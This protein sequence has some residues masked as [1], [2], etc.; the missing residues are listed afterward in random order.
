MVLKLDTETKRHK[1]A[2]M[3]FKARTAGSRLL[4]N[5]RNKDTCI[6]EEICMQRIEN[7]AV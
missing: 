2:D 1:A 6:L 5:R 7:I 4:E 3:K